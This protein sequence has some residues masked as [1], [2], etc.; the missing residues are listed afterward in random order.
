MRSSGNRGRDPHMRSERRVVPIAGFGHYGN[1]RGLE[2]MG[3]GL[4]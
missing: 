2:K 4:L 3:K 1:G